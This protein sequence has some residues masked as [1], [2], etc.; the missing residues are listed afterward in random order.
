MKPNSNVT[1]LTALLSATTSLVVMVCFFQID[2]IVHG[3]LYSYGLEFSY[4]WADPY[5]MLARIVFAMGWLN[6]IIALVVQLYNVK[7]NYIAERSSRVVENALARAHALTADVADEEEASGE[8]SKETKDEET[9]KPTEEAPLTPPES[10]AK[11]KKEEPQQPGQAPEQEPQQ[12]ET[13]PEET[14]SLIDLFN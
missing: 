14:P 6:I 2:K 4:S 3:T 10:E 1:S 11:E 8:E 7:I 5:W 13:E 9:A 12:P